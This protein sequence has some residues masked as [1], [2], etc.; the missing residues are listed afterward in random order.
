MRLAQVYNVVLRYVLDA[1]VDHGPLAGSRRRLQCWLHDVDGH[2]AALGTATKARLLL[3]ELGPTYVKVGQLVSSQSQ[4]L[5]DDWVAELARLQ[6]DV[7]T[8]PYE[9]V[10]RIITED[11]GGPPDQLFERFERSPLAAASLGQVHRARVDG[12][13]VAVKV[14]RPGAARRVRADLGIMTNLTRYLERQAAWA[15]EV[16]LAGIVDEFG[17]NV[18]TELD[19]YSEAYNGRRLAATVQDVSGV[20]I[21]RIYSGLSSTRVLTMDFVDG[22][23]I[24]D[25]AAIRAAGIDPVRLSERFLEGAVK[26][27]LVDGFFHGDPHPGNVMVDLSTGDV[28]MIDLGMCGQLTL[29]QRFTLIQLLVVA[30]RQDVTGMAQVMRDL[31]TPFR[32]VDD[33]DYRRDFERRVGRFLDPDS[34]A[35]LGDAMTVGFRVLRDHGL[36]LDP[37]FTLAVKAMVQA[38]VIATTLW[39]KGGIL[40]SGYEI[41]ERLLRQR[42]TGEQLG[43]AGARGAEALLLD[44]VRQAPRR[45]GQAGHVETGGLPAAAGSVP[46]PA[47]GAHPAF[48]GPPPSPR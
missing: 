5:P 21:P 1:A 31:S 22:V 42:L 40:T 10:A 15:R 37:S 4:V 23:T 29:Q 32:A 13:E 41:A 48:A 39:P 3:Q 34:D 17:R 11:L 43:G 12:R 25:V 47:G 14:R 16:G 20:D 26:Q 2:P 19:Y 6:Q 27:L 45:Y 30:R 24:V 18:L 46:A 35:P 28:Q 33:T 9:D 38:E 44:L 36:R 7:A 8:F